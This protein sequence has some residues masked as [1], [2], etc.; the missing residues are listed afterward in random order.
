MRKPSI[1][2]L[3]LLAG[4]IIPAGLVFVWDTAPRFQALR[5]LRERGVIAT[6]ESL[7]VAIEAD[8][9]RTLQLLH[10]AGVPFDGLDSCGRSLLVRAIQTERRSIVHF[11]LEKAPP[12]VDH[13]D[14]SGLTPLAHA[15]ATGNLEVI[16]SILART[17]DPNIA[18]EF[19]GERIHPLHKAVR[20]RNTGLMT[21]LLAHPRLDVNHQDAEGMTALHHAVQQPDTDILQAL[22]DV[23]RSPDPHAR[24]TRGETALDNAVRRRQAEV[25]RLLTDH[26]AF[27]S[28]E[29]ATKLLTLSIDNRDPETLRHLLAKLDEAGHAAPSEK[30]RLLDYAYNAGATGCAGELIVAGADSDACLRRALHCGDSFM[31][32]LMVA[33]RAIADDGAESLTGGLLEP[34]LFS[35]NPDCVDLLLQ[36]G[37]DPDQTTTTG[38]RIL[39]LAIAA[40]NEHM[41]A[42]LLKAG[43]ETDF[44]LELP[45]SSR[46]SSFFWGDVKTRFYL[47]KDRGLTPLMLACLTEQ[48]ACVT[49]LLQ[50]GANRNHYSEIFKRYP[51]SYA[52]ERGNVRIMQMVL[53][54]EAGDESRKVI[55]SIDNQRATFYRDNEAVMSF[56]VS[57]G[58]KGFPTPPGR[59]VITNKYR[60]WNSTIYRSAMPFFMRLNC[61]D[62]G[63]HSGSV[64]GYPASHGCVRVPWAKAKHLYSMME[65]GDLVVIDP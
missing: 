39:A 10:A 7:P 50:E 32:S 21:M 40:R 41:V 17:R 3:G 57:T 33:Q 2:L 59:Y 44:R 13:V 36:H 1:C 61:G 43:A 29:Q 18:V 47:K 65:I 20:E 30:T 53:G 35:G 12:A 22:L 42:A 26:A 49:R 31:A 37:A 63:L 58:R 55:V 48:E 11:L 25:V 19:R 23:R 16:R 38:Q 24:D 60:N 54:R 6:P 8:D 28:R 52:A 5:E 34:A 64:P 14:G 9:F 62:I 45:V 46:F 15:L 27:Q 4:L 56:S 51:V